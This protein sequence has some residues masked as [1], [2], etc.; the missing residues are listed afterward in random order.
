MAKKSERELDPAK[1]EKL[2]K[3]AA[4]ILAEARMNM[5]LR[6]P[7]TGNVSMSL[8]IVPTRDESNPTACTNG[9]S[10]YFDIDFL[11][12]LSSDEVLFVLAH[13][14]YHNV[15]SHALRKEGRDHQLFN[16]ACDLEVNE[17]LRAD[18]LAVPRDVLLV[19]KFGF[20]PQLSAE[21]Y[22]ELLLKNA[23]S[24]KQA[25]SMGGS[26][27][28]MSGD[29]QESSSGDNGS[30]GSSQKGQGKTKKLQGQFD[31]H[32][33]QN[34]NGLESGGQQKSDRYGKVGKDPDV[35]PQFNPADLEKIREAVV[36]A[37]Q[38]IERSRGEL[39]G[40]LK[41]LVKKI[42][43]PELDWRDLL[44][45][46]VTRASGD[47]PTWNKPN[48]RFA[49][50]G[51][52][53]PSH[54]GKQLKV[55]VGLDTSGSTEGDMEKF[56]NEV[57]GIVSCF[58]GYELSIIHCDT[59]VQHVDFFDEGNIFDPTVEGYHTYGGGGTTLRPIF[60]YLSENSVDPD[61]IVMFTDGWIDRIPAE[62]SN[63]VPTL[64]VL[65]GDGRKDDIE[66]G[67]ITKFKR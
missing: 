54:E 43:E 15:L 10:I 50:S 19:D 6:Y 36:A 30:D 4:M 40:H 64:W 17:M 3:N 8:E 23:H 16:V 33:D 66:F 41:G 38:A 58:N 28:P 13:E 22:Y 39:P 20:P 59:S 32:I 1:L 51:M 53:L 60:D 62:A 9:K 49:W 44:S 34:G 11:S 37:A 65:T 24:Q 12:T 5:Q 63:G 31:K 42:T 25:K 52:F 55:A 48:R 61:V 57:Y 29:S 21:E 2:K 26:G 56:I 45:Q 47:E 46:Y 7:F 27:M 35:N 18:G 14:V 67:E